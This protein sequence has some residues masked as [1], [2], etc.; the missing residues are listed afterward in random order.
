MLLQGLVMAQQQGRGGQAGG[1]EQRRTEQ[2]ASTL[3]QQD[4]QLDKSQAHAAKPLRHHQRR[5]V[6]LLANPLPDFGVMALG[7]VHRRAHGMRVAGLS[8]KAL[9]T[10]ANHQVFFGKSELHWA[11]SARRMDEAK[12]G[13]A[14]GG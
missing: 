2:V 5:P 13:A 6:Q 8:E 1:G 9:G 12:S 14:G 11:V 3:L 4:R 10:V 7:T